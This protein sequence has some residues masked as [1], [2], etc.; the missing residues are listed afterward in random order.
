MTKRIVLIL[1][2]IFLLLSAKNA[3]SAELKVAA[4][5]DGV[6]ASHSLLILS[7]GSLWAW[8]DNSSGQL[9]ISTTGGTVNTPVQVGTDT[10]WVDIAAGY[11]F[12]LGLKS[13]G[14]LW[15]WGDNISG[16]LGDGTGV[17]SSKDRPVKIT[18]AIDSNGNTVAFG[19]VISFAAGY[20]HALA[21]TSDGK[22]WAWGDNGFGQ[23]G[24]GDDTGADKLLPVQVGTDTNWLRVGAGGFHSL[25][26]K[27]DETLYAFGNNSNGQLGYE[28]ATCSNTS[29]CPPPDSL[30]TP[31]RIIPTRVCTGPIGYMSAPYIHGCTSSDASWIKIDGGEAHSVG[32]KS[33]GTLWVFGYNGN[34]QLGVG[35]VPPT[36]ISVATKVGSENNWSDVRA[37]AFHTIALKNDSTLWASGFNLFGQLGTGD[38]VSKSSFTRVGSDTNW[39]KI[40]ASG[41][42]S[43]GLKLTPSLYTWGRNS[44][45]QIG[46]GTKNDT[47]IPK[48][49]SFPKISITPSSRTNDFNI[50]DL[51]NETQP[52]E[53]TVKSVGFLPTTINTV[54]ISEDT[55]NFI[56]TENSCSNLS[57]NLNQSCKISF[58]FK[59]AS[60]G[61]KLL[62]VNLNS[63]DF[64]EPT[65]TLKFIGVGRS[66]LNVTKAG[67]GSGVVTSFPADINCGSSCSSTYTDIKTVSLYAAA[68]QG[69]EFTGWSGACSGI[70]SC[71]VDT[72]N[73][74]SVVANFKETVPPTGSILINNNNS[75]TKTAIVSLSLTCND[76][77]SGCYEMQFSE[78]NVNWS[79]FEPFSTTKSYT[80]TNVSEGEKTVYVK[81]KDRDGNV[82]QT[83]SD[84]IIYD[85]TPPVTNLYPQGGTYNTPQLITMYTNETATIY[86]STDGSTPTNI[87]N[88]A[89]LIDSSKTLKFYAED[90]A[91]NKETERTLSYVIDT[92]P[93]VGSFTINGGAA[94][95][96]SRSVTLSI[97]CSD[98]E[99]GCSKMM[100]SEDG[101]NWTDPENFSTIKSYTLSQGD[102]TKTIYLLLQSGAGSWS[103]AITRSIK[104]DTTP[105]NIVTIPDAGTYNT[106]QIITLSSNE[107]A[108]IY[109]TTD[110]TTPTTSSSIYNNP[111]EINATT[112]L[113]FFAIDTAGNSG[114]VLS[115]TYTID[116]TPPEGSVT[117]NNGLV[118]TNNRVVTLSFSVT[119]LTDV[120]DVQIMN[121]VSPP[122]FVTNVYPYSS[123]KYWTLSAGD[124]LKAVFVR[125]KNSAGNW[126]NIVSDTII[127]DTIN[128]VVTVSKPT[129]TYNSTIN[130]ELFCTDGNGSGCD[131]LYYTLDNSQPTTSSTQYT[132]PILISDNKTLKVLAL[133]KAGNQSLIE[134]FTYT[135]DTTPP[136]GTIEINNGDLYTSSV[137]ATL[138]LSGSE[139][140]S[141]TKMQFSTD[142]VTWSSEEPYNTFKIY[143]LS[144]GDGQKTVCVRYNDTAGNWSAPICDTIILDQT[145]PVTTITPSAGLYNTA[146]TVTLHVNEPATICYTIDGTD[147]I[148]SSSK[149]CQNPADQKVTFTINQTTTV[150]YV[151]Y[152]RAYNYETVK[153]ELFSIDKEPPTGT[154]TITEGLVTNSTTVNLNLA[155]SDASGVTKMQFSNDG[156]N[157]SA[158]EDYKT[159]KV[160]QLTTGDGQKT[161]YARFKDSAGNWSVPVTSNITLDTTPPI[162]TV[163]P[164]GSA[165]NTPKQVSISANEQAFI[166]FTLDGTEP[167]L[168]SQIYVSPITIYE[169]ATLKFFA[170]DNAGNQT[171]VRSEHYIIDTEPP[172][173]FASVSGGIYNSAK[174]VAITSNE[175][176]TIYYTTNGTLPNINSTKY[177]SPLSINETTTLKFFAVDTVGNIGNTITEIYTID[178]V[179]PSGSLMINNGSSYA[180]QSQVTLTITASDSNGIVSMEFS[181]DNTNW[182]SPEAYTTTKSYTLPTGDGTKTVYVRY[183]DTAGNISAAVSS[184]II[185]DTTKP[186]GTITIN[187]GAIATNQQSV[188]LTLSASDTSG[189]S[190]MEFSNDGISWSAP[191]AYTTTKQWLLP[192]GDG[193]KTVYVRYTDIAGNVSNAISDSIIYST[194]GA[195]GSLKINNNSLYTNTTAVTLTISATSASGIATMSF[196]NDGTNWT[197]PEAYA[198]TKSYTLPTGDGTKTVYVKLK[199][200]AGNES[201]VSSSIILDTTKPTGTITINSGSTHTNNTTVTLTLSA[202]DTSGISK[203]EFSNDGTNWTTPEAYTTTKSYTLPTGDGTKTVYVRYTDTAGNVSNAISSSI[204]LDTTKPTGTI[205]IN[206]GATHTNNTAVTLTLSASDTSGIS[207][208]EFSND[209]TNWSSPEAYTTTKSYT[210]PTGDGT[211]T[212]YVRYTDTAG[213]VSNAISSSIIL[214]TTKPTVTVT[215]TPGYYGSDQTITLTASENAIIYY[216]LDG[217]NPTTQSSVY[218]NPFTITTS[219]VIKYLAKDLADNFS[220]VYLANFV[221]DKT[222]PTGT[223]KI[224]GGTAYTTTQ[225]VSLEISAQDSN[226][227]D[228]MQ[229]SNDNQNWTQPEIFTST[230]DWQLTAGDG[231]KTVYVKLIDKAGNFS[232]ISSTITLDTTPPSAKLSINNDAPF[233]NTTLVN[234]TLTDATENIDLVSFSNDG[235]NW[236]SPEKFSAAKNWT[237]TAGDGIKNVYVVLKDNAGNWSSPITKS[238][239]LDT[240]P[241]STTATPS[242]GKFKTPQ[243]V[244]LTTNENAKIYYTIDGSQPTTSSTQYSAP[245]EVLTSTAIKFFS[246]DPAGN[247]EKVKVENYTIDAVPPAGSISIN[248]GKGYT[249]SE[250]VTLNISASDPNG[251]A[252]MQFSND[253]TNWSAE[254]NYATTKS[255]TLTAGDGLKTVYA[256]FIDTIGNTSEPISDSII[257]DKTPPTV[258]VT[259]PQGVYSSNVNVTLTPSEQATI[260]YTLN[261]DL[262]TT[263]STVYT[264]SFSILTSTTVKIL[265]VD[266]AGN[267]SSVISVN[268]TIDNVPPTGTITI[269]EGLVTNSTTVNLNLAASDASG[270]TKMQF[271]N[272]GVNWSAEEDYKTTKV[273]QLTTGDGQ[274]TVYARFKDS[275]GNWSVPVSTKITLDTVVPKSSTNIAAGTYLNSLSVVLSVNETGAK[276]YYT[277]DGSEPTTSSNVYS[278]PIEITAT[279]TLK[280][281]AV[282]AAG[283]KE[284]VN[285]VTYTIKFQSDVTLSINGGNSFT[286]SKDVLLNITS[287]KPIIEMQFSNDGVTWTN[288]EP[289]S[290]TKSWQ[291]VDTEGV[292]TVYARFKDNFGNISDAVI[293]SITLDKTPPVTTISVS[294]GLYN[295]SK[296]VILSVNEPQAK[297]YYTIDGTEPT[298]A[299]KTFSGP[300]NIDK[301]TVLKY[302]AKDTAG[303]KEQVKTENFTIDTVLPTC[304]V[305]INNGALYTNNQIVQLQIIGTDENGVTELQVTNDTT[306]WSSV[307]SFT[308]SVQKSWTLTSGDGEKTVYARVK[309]AA[310]NW[311]NPVSAKITLDTKAPITTPSVPEGSLNTAFFLSLTTDEPAT[312]YYS[313]DNGQTFGKYTEAIPITKDT[314]V[315]FYA[316]DKVNNKEAEQTL[317]YSIDFQPPLNIS[318]NNKN[319]YTNSENIVVNFSFTKQDLLEEETPIAMQFSNDGT[320]F[321]DE[322]P[323]STGKAWTLQGGDGEKTVYVKFKDKFGNWSKSFVQ[324]VTKAVIILDRVPPTTSITPQAGN[325]TTVPYEIKLT[326]NEP[327]VKIYYSFD[328]GQTYN[329]Y[330]TPISLTSSKNIKY[331][332]EDAAG[333]KEQEKSVSY[334]VNIKPN[335]TFLINNGQSATNNTNVTLT[336]TA[337]DTSQFSKI[338]FSNDGINW[339]PEINFTNQTSWTLSN[340]NGEKTV[341]MRIKDIYG[342]ISQIYT[343]KINLDDTP[344]VIEA[345]LPSGT[346]YS[347]Q[348]VE[349]K[350]N[351]PATIYYTTNGDL[352]T[353]Y[354]NVYSSPITISSDTLLKFFGVDSFGNRSEIK[355]VSYKIIPTETITLIGT[356]GVVR[357]DNGDVST[358]VDP[359]TGNPRIDLEYNFGLVVKDSGG[360]PKSVKIFITDKL[361][362][363]S[364]DYVSYDLSCTG[365]FSTGASCSFSTKL[366]AAPQTKYYFEV[367][368]SDGNKIKSPTDKDA[369]DGPKAELLTG[370]NI[371]AIPRDIQNNPMTSKD[372]FG[373]T[374][375]YRW[376]SE[377]VTTNTIRGHYERLNSTDVIVV[378][379]GYFVQK[380]QTSIAPPEFPNISDSF[381]RIT[382]KAGW[383]LVSNPYNGNVRLRDLK[384][385]KS[386]S[387]L[388][389]SWLEA[390]KNNWIYNAAYFYKGEDWGKLYD[391]E[392]AGGNKEGELTPWLG[393]WIYVAKGDDTY[394]LEIPKP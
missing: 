348:K 15:A 185:L 144:S 210:L 182:S 74:V 223:L 99:T 183:T 92:T 202:S 277:T 333:N 31:D 111:I 386:G 35:T 302:F 68:E 256:R 4:G 63:N 86:Y 283:N 317:N 367:V 260:Y 201:I 213:N 250:N 115:K 181:N 312:I 27:T 259:P 296:Q 16:Q 138:T 370:Y 29:A 220:A 33:D 295:T 377:G 90:Q 163:S 387:N 53:F 366:G 198:T 338:Q 319:S 388:A 17:T 288:F 137:Y 258:V 72:T 378:G 357:E 209:N 59:P 146:Q 191:E 271:S 342:N 7:D 345:T 347:S 287:Q 205:T 212:V 123:S 341:Y 332:A 145:P 372:A 91:G 42:H 130:V 12:S 384:L 264:N 95:T 51:F 82:S 216:T 78:D 327:N 369:F 102:G 80:F 281:F 255:W 188:T 273:W 353:E 169:T 228:K 187:S 254:E 393:Y 282:D 350:S 352:P 310:G 207:K 289:Y 227:V 274:K 291:L 336:I 376:V 236:S 73:N 116:Q 226:G 40:D 385:I 168:A 365:D 392:T 46:D 158:E 79:S 371:L 180:N 262:P 257:L 192:P 165:Y 94:A 304:S 171:A 89:I 208:M 21:V 126:S 101:S 284:T 239:Y 139:S 67:S 23:L 252:K 108:T 184:S 234:L 292:K 280:F 148:N 334:I 349:L 351:E 3:L 104:L 179:P 84:S 13:D 30:S 311:S 105:P 152:D 176:A 1:I 390:A 356:N 11:K 196:S 306:Q 167:T 14:S 344:P 211:K 290:T 45:G 313:V 175:P 358:N 134:T 153:T 121:D 307:E 57:L 246:V 93:P 177:T 124:G 155:A 244:T 251:V 285:S 2:S 54:T 315:K 204:I 305:L 328:D 373:D 186:T 10:D 190:K 354:S 320:T 203:M 197:T 149:V 362:P 154:I 263:S 326:S 219:T 66:T 267:Q 162:L 19:N 32:I 34:G 329:I 98:T 391:F 270:V 38:T 340:L 8:G 106:A 118:A 109:Y 50:A 380:A 269:T 268:Y 206:S 276:I 248:T 65:M 143:E 47:N 58:K 174:T 301:T 218:L 64:I 298:E 242:G 382:L 286:N 48:D 49:I 335:L 381:V 374:I 355:Q 117:I 20:Y 85:K 164:L 147:P 22:L 214:D 132:T 364:Q 131:K 318:L 233:T 199:D 141:Q 9:G 375:V 44:F 160:W 221:I 272:D 389:L 360:T 83:Y 265:A 76:S 337:L 39:S 346:Y 314:T 275:A 383:N 151:S 325:I 195:T 303:N 361:N 150:K 62:T 240:V 112:T 28:E 52:L 161:V 279:T 157:W 308:G 97:S 100:F 133:D 330:N 217:S 243:L 363:T 316:V 122:D 129:G 71:N 200:N 368:L 103:S 120:T 170:V 241:P 41:Y 172:L 299:S 266:Q 300:I 222:A 178:T 331:Y 394:I 61:Q 173:A 323:F 25:A 37:G 113:K 60:A 297:I 110:G 87:Y 140:S 309:D 26:I 136:T 359:A 238:I 55:G 247:I 96:N 135:F 70:S 24:N 189:I 36:Q 278:S 229:L 294:G 215:P 142:G 194:E 43:I 69:S 231:D 322:E 107:P 56:N 261:G 193:T 127:L 224:N 18:S 156:V 77:G 225:N 339:A 253:G 128:P 5:G 166:F 159:T 321:S 293:A 232:V 230:K 125:F 249:N 235:N 245:I 6:T 75:Y 88:G 119:G 81:F 237:L 343:A 114:A 379:E 324:D